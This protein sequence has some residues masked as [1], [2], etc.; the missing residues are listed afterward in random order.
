MAT[1][2]RKTDAWVQPMADAHNAL[3]A[4]IGAGAF[5]HL[6]ISEVKP[7][8]ALATPVGLQ[9]CIAALKDLI[10][11]ARFMV[12]DTLG[13]KV[14]DATVLPLV[15]DPVDLPSCLTAA[16]AIKTWYNTHRASTTYHYNAD[17]TNVTAATNATDQAS[18]ETLVAELQVDMTA[19]GNSGPSAPSVRVM[20]A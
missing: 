19:H 12:A 1:Q 5:F 18:L 9:A 3:K 10:G 4:Q 8:P 15:S 17:S 14:V 13:H 16:N 20:Q 6:D 11:V 7:N 2:I